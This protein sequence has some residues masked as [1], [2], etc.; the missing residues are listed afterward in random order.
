MQLEIL[1]TTPCRSAHSQIVSYPRFCWLR[2]LLVLL[3]SL[4][5][6]TRT[7]TAKAQ[8]PARYSLLFAPARPEIPTAV[9]GNGEDVADDRSTSYSLSNNKRG[10]VLPAQAPPNHRTL[11]ADDRHQFVGCTSKGGG[12]CSM[13]VNVLRDPRLIPNWNRDAWSKAIAQ[14]NAYQ[15]L[16]SSSFNGQ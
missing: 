14:Y 15:Q 10:T 1:C 5:A 16:F 9:L 7:A 4:L 3:F 2:I 8:F 12:K 13:M 6:I 11:S